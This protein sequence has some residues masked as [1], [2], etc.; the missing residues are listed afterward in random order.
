M[1]HESK[2]FP[3]DDDSALCGTYC[4]HQGSCQGAADLGLLEE[5]L[6][7][8]VQLCRVCV[9]GGNED[10]PQV[11]QQGGAVDSVMHFMKAQNVF[12]PLGYPVFQERCH[13]VI[14]SQAM[15]T[16]VAFYL[17]SGKQRALR[18]PLCCLLIDL[19]PSG[20]I[21]VFLP[22]RASQSCTPLSSTLRMGPCVPSSLT[23]AS[24]E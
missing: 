1:L 3:A 19:F 20:F 12:F 5:P 21:C 15:L 14:L 23:L 6:Y 17:P 7:R 10:H 11:G 13:L 9:C 8:G 18:P 4:L 2:V 22:S 16:L 24:S